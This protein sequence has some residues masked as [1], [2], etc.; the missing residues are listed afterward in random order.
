MNRHVRSRSRGQVLP[1]AGGRDDRAHRHRRHRDRLGFSW[2]LARQEQNAADPAALAAARFIT[3]PD[4][5]TGI[6]QLRQRDGWTAACHYAR[7]TASSSR[8]TRVVTPLLAG[9]TDRGHLA[10]KPVS[11]AR[12]RQS[13]RRPGHHR[14]PPR[15]F[16]GRV[17]GP[18]DPT[19]SSGAVAA[20]QRGNVN[21]SSLIALKP[22]GCDTARVRGNSTISIYP[23][24]GY[25]GP[26]GL[27]AGQLGLW[28]VHCGQ[29]LHDFITGALNINGTAALS[30]PQVNVH[31]GCKGPSGQPTGV[32]DEASAQIGDPLGALAFPGWN[33]GVPGAACGVGAANTTSTGSRVAATVAAAS[34]GASRPIGMPGPRVGLQCVELNPASTTAGGTSVPRSG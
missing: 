19:V 8:R 25:T 34:R 3:D 7:R 12:C 22:D 23:V 29:Q 16:F 32:L 13:R 17:F 31:G 10:A 14:G 21:S 15:A 5:V 33:T 28:H 1:I 4:P 26:G 11:P 9:R 27:C 2:M 18:T 6:Q 20:R 30:A 24:P